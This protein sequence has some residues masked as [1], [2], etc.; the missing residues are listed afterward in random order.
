MAKPLKIGLELTGEDALPTVLPSASVLPALG[1]GGFCRKLSHLLHS[2]RFDDSTTRRIYRNIRS[3]L[4][5]RP[6]TDLHSS[7]P[8]RLNI[9]HRG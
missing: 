5:L 1:G 6:I 9:T 4:A 3:S 7:A 8:Q 2:C